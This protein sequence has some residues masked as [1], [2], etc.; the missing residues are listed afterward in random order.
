MKNLFKKAI[1]VLNLPVKLAAANSYIKYMEKERDSRED[2][3]SELRIENATLKYK[4]SK[5]DLADARVIRL[6]NMLDSMRTQLHARGATDIEREFVRTCIDIYNN[7]KMLSK[8]RFDWT[9]CAIKRERELLAG[10]WKR[11]NIA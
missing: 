10:A 4:C 7:N 1:M 9:V 5:L 8:S 11:D 6:R 3:L 2:L